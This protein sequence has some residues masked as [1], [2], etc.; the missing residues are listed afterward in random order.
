MPQPRTRNK[1]IDAL[2]SLAAEHAWRDVTLEAIAERAGVT[3]S[4]LRGAYDGRIAI[5]ADY[6]RR[7]DEAVLAG[8]DPALAK[9]A[10]REKLFDILFARLEAQATHRPALRNIVHAARRDPLFA[11]EL[12]AIVITSMGWM[13]T[14]AGI[15]ASGGRGVIK[16]QALALVWAR[17]MR[18][19]LD[20][21]DP[22][23]AKSMA[24]LDKALKEA[25]RAKLRLDR[26]KRLACCVCPGA[27]RSEPA[28]DAPADLSEAHPT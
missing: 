25:E 17:V 22:D 12:N 19:F 9:E 21:D 5:L 26:V 15:S 16:A 6:V 8:I 3:L 23:L 11:L 1:I 2:L 24:A 20:D 7:T 28:S 27:R 18:V 4:A 10:P 14:A 13:L